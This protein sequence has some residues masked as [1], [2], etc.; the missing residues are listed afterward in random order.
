MAYRLNKTNGELLVELVDGQIDTT[1]T[2]ITLVG[3]N[4]KGFGEFLNENY[5]KLLENFAKTSSPGAP[6]TGQLWY[7]TGEE[8]LKIYTGETF[9]SAGGPVVSNVQPN[10]VLGDLWIDSEN[11]KLYFFDGSELIL[12]GPNYDAAQ[13]KT[14][15]EAVTVIDSNSQDQTVLF[16]YIAGALT[17][18][19]SKATFRPLVNIVGYPVD[20]D[21]LSTPRRQI[22]RQ[23]FNPVS[24]DYWF[25]GTAQST[26][27]LISDASEEFTEAN[28]MKTDRDTSTTGSLAIKDPAGKGLTIYSQDKETLG[29]A[30][31]GT[32]STIETRRSNTDISINTKQENADSIAFYA[33]GSLQ[34]VGIYTNQPSVE[35]DVNGSGRYTGDLEVEGNLLVTGDT[36]YLN[37]STLRVEDKNIELGLLNDSTQGNDAQID[38]AGIIVRSSDGSKDFTWQVETGSWTSNQS[39]DLTAGKSFKIA[40]ITTLSSN[41]LHDTVIYAEGLISIGT[42]Q[43]LSVNGNVSI[44]DN[45]SVSGALNITST[46]TITINNQN[47]SGVLDPVTDLDVANKRYVDTQIDNEPVVLSLDLTGLSNPVASFASNGPYIDVKNI[48]DFMYPASEKEEGTVARVYGTSYSNTVVTGIDVSAATNKSYVSV[49]VDPEDSTTPQLES[50]VQDIAFSPVSGVANFTP[51]RAQI[52]FIVNSGVWQWVRTT[53][54]S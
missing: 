46:G 44:K 11:N 48:L 32:V 18:I 13:G 29:I 37:V 39:I 10:L 3:R 24:E 12:V 33:S 35:L 19:L 41:R 30:I 6:L 38:G 16:F 43:Q 40:D 14:G 23:G 22:I 15:Y 53:V 9:K 28:F 20:P 8:R 49:I 47:V 26:R 17:G 4:Y 50:V 36:T 34:R 7:D 1:S 21:D 25:R 54:V 42:L 52:E 31:N 27:S 2:D 5:I 51:D 45:L